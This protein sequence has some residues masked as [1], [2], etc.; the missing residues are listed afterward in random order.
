MF[1]ISIQHEGTVPCVIPEG[2]L[3]TLN[4]TVFNEKIQLLAEQEDYLIIDFK[5]CNYLASSGIRVLMVTAKKLNARGGSL[6]LAS[7]PPEVFQVIEMTGLQKVFPVF[8]DPAAAIEEIRRLRKKASQSSEIQIG[9]LNFQVQA[10]GDINLPARFWHKVDIVGYNELGISV[11]IGSPAES[12][13][14]DGENRGT[15][16]IIGNCAGFIPFDRKFPQEF[17]VLMDASAGGIFLQNAISFGPEPSLQVRLTNPSKIR[18]S[19]LTDAI[20]Q[21]PK[22][23]SQGKPLAFVIADFGAPASV[24]LCFFG[25]TPHAKGFHGAKFVLNSLPALQPGEQLSDYMS[26]SLTIENIESVESIEPLYLPSSVYIFQSPVV[27]VFNPDQLVD[28]EDQRIRIETADGFVLDPYKAFLARRLYTD[29]GRVVIRQLHGGYSAQ[30]FQV[31]SFD[32]DGRKLRPTVLKIANRNLISREAERCQKYALPYIL[33]NSAIVLGTAFYCDNGALRYNFVGIGGEQ[34]KL[35][36]LT[37]IFNEWP[38]DQ[39]EPL[40]DKI[41]LQILNPWYG[42]SV[43]GDIFPYR[44]QDPTLTFF[45]TLCETAKEV[46]AIDPDEKFMTISETGEKRINPYWFL[47]YEYPRRRNHP[48][49]YYSAICHG[50]LNMQNILLDKEMNV[51]LIDFSETQPRSAISDFARLEAIFMIEHA[52]ISNEKELREMIDF[53]TRFYTINDL[54]QLPDITWQG[55]EPDNMKRNLA[56]TLKMRNYALNCTS[57]HPDIVPYYIALLEWI[58]PIVCYGGTELPVKKLSAYVSGLLC[59]KI[60]EA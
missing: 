53:T 49:G 52:P 39:L 34:T 24:T 40:F 19:I 54:N 6:M 9:N 38:A 47:R 32:P 7:L 18:A 45:P 16:I 37:H 55:S 35:K 41:F 50:D 3:D 23:V 17:R 20:L 60:L 58:L 15:F 12:L 31:E 5:N 42:Q 13:A 26:R 1:N 46:L 33:N 36:W 48:I 44:D 51:Y 8:K 11:G 14:D 57:G 27:W 29:S 59:Q 30:T 25:D 4:S 21:M 56:L 10:Y 43:K 22:M 28:A 2:R